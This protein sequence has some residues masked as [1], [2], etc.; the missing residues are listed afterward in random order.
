MNRVTYD[1]SNP[2]QMSTEDAPAPHAPIGATVSVPP[3]GK[4]RDTETLTQEITSALDQ[5]VARLIDRKVTELGIGRRR[6]AALVV[7]ELRKL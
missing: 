4:E 1:E 7:Q 5:A 6:A 3:P 2:P